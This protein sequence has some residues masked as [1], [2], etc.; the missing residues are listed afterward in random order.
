ML[1]KNRNRQ[2]KAL[3]YLMIILFF[4]GME[5]QNT[6]AIIPPSPEVASLR[7]FIGV[8]IL[9]YTGLPNIWMSITTYDVGSKSF[10]KTN[11]YHARA[12]KVEEIAP[13]FAI[14]WVISSGGQFS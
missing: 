2:T 10:P 4:N 12:L 7:K 13:R 9:H 14:S 8:P 5:V 3:V 11:N 6:P 1:F